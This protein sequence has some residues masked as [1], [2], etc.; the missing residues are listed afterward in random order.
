MTMYAK[1]RRQ[2]KFNQK[3]KKVTVFT[4]ELRKIEHGADIISRMLD[5]EYSSEQE[6]Y[7]Y[8]KSKS[9]EIT[10]TWREA[11]IAEYVYRDGTGAIYRSKGVDT[12]IGKTLGEMEQE[13]KEKEKAYFKR[14]DQL[15]PNLRGDGSWNDDWPQEV[16][17]FLAGKRPDWSHTQKPKA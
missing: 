8:I 3:G 2:Q 6:L 16:K 13:A 14:L 15:P 5:Q 7:D 11:E 4:A 9:Y 12:S 1:I 17:E 10:N